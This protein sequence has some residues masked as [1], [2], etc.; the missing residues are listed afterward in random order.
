MLFPINS[1]SSM[2]I[3]SSIPINHRKED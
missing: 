2:V 1:V 3:L